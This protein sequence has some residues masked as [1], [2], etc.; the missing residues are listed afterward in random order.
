M[1]LFAVELAA[2]ATLAADVDAARAGSGLDPILRLFDAAGRE[3]AANDD[4][5]GLDSLIRYALAGAG[6]YYVGVSGYSNFPYD[7]A[8]G[9]SGRAGSTGAYEL[10]LTLTAEADPDPAPDPDPQPDPDPDGYEYVA[11]RVDA[12]FEDISPTGR[13]GLWRWADDEYFRLSATQLAPNP[14]G[15]M[16][17][18]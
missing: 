16:C 12:T 1:D 14:S 7:P 4:T 6:T 13:A 18:V 2:P 15:L 17:G 9:G 8:T 11:Q 5:H 10:S 3:L